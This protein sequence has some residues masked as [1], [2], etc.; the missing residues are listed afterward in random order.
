MNLL[1]SPVLSFCAL[2]EAN[3][4]CPIHGVFWFS[5]VSMRLWLGR[6]TAFGTAAAQGHL[7]RKDGRGEG[8]VARQR[9]TIHQNPSNDGPEFF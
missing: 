6:N 1:D 3:F 4:Y 9:S 2:V 5:S 8:L 7:H